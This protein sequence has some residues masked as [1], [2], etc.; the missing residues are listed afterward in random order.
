MA[1]AERVVAL[2]RERGLKVAT[3]ESCTGGLISGL[4]TEIA[5]SSSVMDYGFVTYANEAKARL[6][7]VSRETLKAH[8][9][10]SEETAREMAE[11]ALAAAFSDVAVSCT[12]IAG[13]GGGT[14]EKPV[15]LVYLG[16]A[17]RG[18]ETRV[19]K[20]LYGDIGRST[21]RLKT[22][23]D[24]LAMIEDALISA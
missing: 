24:A 23:A 9:A 22:A 15:G 12:G 2:L 19:L 8:G 1:A 3:A 20:R 13:P 10:V 5:G 17:R 4:L 6:I 7:G 11:G 16:L 14:A 18:V 21:V